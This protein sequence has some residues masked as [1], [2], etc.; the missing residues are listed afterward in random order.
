[1][2]EHSAAHAHQFE[3]AEQQLDATTFGMWVFLLTEI[4]LFGGLF[5]G[6]TV[7]RWSYPQAFAGASRYLDL[8]L[9][10]VNTVV[11]ISSSL[12]MALAVRAA[13]LGARRSL[14]GCLLATLLLGGVFLVIKGFEYHH[15]YVEHHIPGALFVFEGPLANQA[16]IFF[17]FYFALTGAHAVHMIVGAG[18]LVYFIFQA[19]RGRYTAQ[20]FGPVEIM[21]L[22]WH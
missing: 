20:Y 12:T 14:V 3:D 13:Q 16:Q 21:G 8:T 9:G 5:A 2:S 11:L 17:S 4:L 15:K 22:Y 7:Y 6:Y 1:M 19:A 10:A 18:L